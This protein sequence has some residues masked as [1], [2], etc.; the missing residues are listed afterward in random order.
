MENIFVTEPLGSWLGSLPAEIWGITLVVAAL[1]FTTLMFVLIVWS[2]A[3]KGLALWKAARLNQKAW[4]IILL[5][6]NTAGLLE[7]IYYFLIARQ[8]EK[9]KN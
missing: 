6:I 4:F 5:V 3:W 9:Q 8:K 2:L 7:I 1:G